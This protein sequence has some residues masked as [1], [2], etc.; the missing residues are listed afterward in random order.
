MPPNIAA[1]NA[2]KGELAAG[3]LLVICGTGTTAAVVD[4]PLASWTGLID[5][6]IE[7]AVANGTRDDAWADRAKADARSPYGNDI[8]AAAEKATD[9]LGGRT[10]AEFA[11]W[12]Y[13][14]VAQLG[15]A[16][17]TLTDQIAALSNAGA[18]IATTNYDDILE[19][20][21]G[22]LPVTWR[23]GHRLR[24]V[25]R[26]EEKAIIHIHGHWS[27][28]ESIIFGAA[29]YAEVI[30][31]SALEA[32]LRTV[33]YAQTALFVGFGAGLED[34]N[35]SGIRRWLRDRVHDG[36]SHYRL[37]RD[38]DQASLATQH[39]H[40]SITAVP[41]GPDYAD[42][43]GYLGALATGG[44]GAPPLR[45]LDIHGGADSRDLTPPQGTSG[46]IELPTS[47]IDATTYAAL[48]TAA[49]QLQEVV[50]RPAPA[51]DADLDT[52]VWAWT[53]AQIVELFRPEIDAVIEASD[54]GESLPAD[55]GLLAVR[56]ANRLLA[57]LRFDDN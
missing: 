15:I 22:L 47:T 12:L 57:M 1:F 41:F 30:A 18:V 53:R 34:P 38:S 19:E 42:L 37:C 29:S 40:D 3:R 27:D 4:S 21:T 54:A 24:R 10:G 36:L 48:Q 14:T 11:A 56:W 50:E 5:N 6:A 25:L 17:T 39:E 2:L 55:Q 20:A 52:E 7:R 35:F 28:P 31:D 51:S 16:D 43:P 13:E 45:A 26:G 44:S 49:A 33:L 23:Q 8:V 32:F 46:H 9:A